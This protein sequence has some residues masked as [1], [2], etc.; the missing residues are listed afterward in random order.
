MWPSFAK[1]LVTNIVVLAV[2]MLLSETVLTSLQANHAD[3][4][5]LVD[6]LLFGLLFVAV[7][8]VNWRLIVGART[9]DLETDQDIHS[10][11]PNAP[12]VRESAIRP[13][14]LAAALGVLGLPLLMVVAASV[15]HYPV[16]ALVGIP[17]GIVASTT[18]FALLVRIH[19]DN[20]L[21]YVGGAVTL[22][23][24]AYIFWSALDQVLLQN[25]AGRQPV[26]G[27]GMSR[28][29]LV[30]PCAVVL[31]RLAI[32]GVQARRA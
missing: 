16:F 11:I 12:P 14:F 1:S 21:A 22:I 30:V 28:G 20:R 27:L 15:T 26:S 32:T 6:D 24:L 9:G 3:F 2:F 7:A 4:I 13:M 23:L 10:A 25:L 19:P 29:L 17:L 18:S 5:W 8:I 31:L